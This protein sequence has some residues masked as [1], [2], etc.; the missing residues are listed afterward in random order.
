M[1]PGAATD[2]WERTLRGS[3]LATDIFAAGAFAHPKAVALTMREI[4]PD[5]DGWFRAIRIDLDR[6]DA[7]E[8]VAVLISDGTLPEPSHIIVRA[9]NGHAHVIWELGRWV[10][11]DRPKAV[12]LFERIREALRV[13]VGGDPAYVGKFQHNPRHADFENWGNGRRW[14]LGELCE[15][16]GDVVWRT[17]RPARQSAID[18]ITA[19][20]GRNCSHFEN[21]RVQAYARVDEFRRQG[22]D[23]EFGELVLGLV[24]AENAAIATPLGDKECGVIAASISNWTWNVYR[25][26]P[27]AAAAHRTTST[28]TRAEYLAIADATR[29]EARR[30]HSDGLGA[31]AIAKQLSRSRRWVYVALASPEPGVQSQPPIR[32]YPSEAPAKSLTGIAFVLDR[33]RVLAAEPVVDLLEYAVER[34]ALE[35]Q[36]IGFTFG[37]LSEPQEALPRRRC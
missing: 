14:E 5:P 30:L 4:A 6:P 27:N 22:R 35:P 28:R 31:T 13:V 15:A 7:L 25:R 23:I 17:A 29:T 12:A 24:L 16:L 3:L 9:T 18:P 21:V 11:R 1:C 37:A 10:R 34:L 36:I 32:T 19:A 33:C 8:H 20:Q 2:H 26:G